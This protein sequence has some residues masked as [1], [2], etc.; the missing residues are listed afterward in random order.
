MQLP[1]PQTFDAVRILTAANQRQ[2]TKEAVVL[3][4]DR[5]GRVHPQSEAIKPE[6]EKSRGGN[7][8]APHGDSA[9]EPGWAFHVTLGKLLNCR[10]L[11]LAGPHSNAATPV[12]IVLYNDNS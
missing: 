6:R 9:E 5:C 7:G 3:N 2:G 12:L 4:A 8:T 11:S 10:F 1:L